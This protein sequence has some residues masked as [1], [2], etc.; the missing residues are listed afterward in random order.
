[1]EAEELYSRK[2]GEEITAQMYNF[3]SKDGTNVALRP[4]MTPS[5]ARLILKAGKKNVI[6][7]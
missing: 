5:L 3:L 2:A 6:A 4:E 7:T 1:L